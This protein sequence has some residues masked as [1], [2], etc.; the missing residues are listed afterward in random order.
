MIPAL[1]L[2]LAAQQPNTSMAGDDSVTVTVTGKRPSDPCGIVRQVF[3]SPVGQP[4][5]TL[6]GEGDPVANWFALTDRD[7]SGTLDAAEFKE[8]ADTWFERVDKD[9]DGEIGP[10]EM[11]VYERDTVPEVSTFERTSKDRDAAREAMKNRK[12]APYGAPVGAARFGL[13]NVPHPL[14][15]GDTDYNRGISRAEL[16][17]VA[18]RAFETLAKGKT[19][20]ALADLPKTPQQEHIRRC[21]GVAPSAG[22]VRAP[23]GTKRRPR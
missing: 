1:L 17:V 2:L 3:I 18:Q 20:I 9:H 8:D 22:T 15:S 10:D 5:R 19:E 14:A 7:N 21:K 16:E 6:A 13:T 12:P 11:I 23:A 4:F